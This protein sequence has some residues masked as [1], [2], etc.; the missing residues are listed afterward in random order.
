MS[1]PW[2]PKG[3]PT[4]EDAVAVFKFKM[5]EACH[6]VPLEIAEGLQ[7]SWLRGYDPNQ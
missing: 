4:Y 7:G 6:P 3:K 5:K 1:L 2:E